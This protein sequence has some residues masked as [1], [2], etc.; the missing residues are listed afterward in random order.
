MSDQL[1]KTIVN[2]ERWHL[3]EFERRNRQSCYEM[4]AVALIA[5]AIGAA[6]LILF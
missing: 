1:W 3:R 4:L 2:R 6:T 5:T